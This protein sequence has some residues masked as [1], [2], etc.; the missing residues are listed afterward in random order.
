MNISCIHKK[1]KINTLLLYIS[2]QSKNKNIKYQY[3]KCYFSS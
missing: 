1:Y 2:T 3:I